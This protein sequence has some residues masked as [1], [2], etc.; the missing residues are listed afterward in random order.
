V[1]MTSAWAVNVARSIV[2]QTPSVINS[3]WFAAKKNGTWTL[4]DV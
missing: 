2:L 1:L 4:I 3:I